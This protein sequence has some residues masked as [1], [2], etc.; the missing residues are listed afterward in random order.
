MAWLLISYAMLHK[1][2]VQLV[3]HSF[4]EEDKIDK[5]R[6]EEEQQWLKEEEEEEIA[7]QQAEGR[8]GSPAS[9]ASPSTPRSA[10]KKAIG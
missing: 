5:E 10:G 8:R 2:I 3:I 7:R 1:L 6:E 9:R 4:I